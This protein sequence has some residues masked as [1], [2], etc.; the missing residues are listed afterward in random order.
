MTSLEMRGFSVSLLPANAEDL[1]ALKAPVQLAAWP[2][3]AP[4]GNVRNNFV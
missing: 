2:G 3:L 1:M 4:L